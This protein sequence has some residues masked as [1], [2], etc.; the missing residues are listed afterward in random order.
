M[1]H[2]TNRRQ[3]LFNPFR[4]GSTLPGSRVEAHA[5]A[6]CCKEVK[7]P[8]CAATVKHMAPVHLGMRQLAMGGSRA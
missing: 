2:S 7:L 4:S 3:S 8:G 6:Q 5:K 1:Q